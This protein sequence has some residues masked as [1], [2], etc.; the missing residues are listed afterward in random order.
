MADEAEG[1][2]EKNAK[3]WYKEVDPKVL[4][5]FWTPASGKTP[6][7]VALDNMYAIMRVKGG[8]ATAAEAEQ[9]RKTRWEE[10]LRV[11][12]ILEDKVGWEPQDG[13]QAYTSD[14][15]ASHKSRVLGPFLLS[16]HL[17]NVADETGE[18]YR[19]FDKSGWSDR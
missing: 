9:V 10:L 4:G 19:T 16:P 5:Q 2:L 14:T 13:Q 17:A 8:K 15:S 11:M 3:L 1:D 12:R 18:G 7:E 6:S